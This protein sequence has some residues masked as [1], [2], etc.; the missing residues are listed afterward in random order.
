MCPY[1]NYLAP[2]YL[3]SLQDGFKRPFSELLLNTTHRLLNEN[4]HIDKFCDIF[5]SKYSSVVYCR[6]NY[7][8]HRSVLICC[9]GCHYYKH[10]NSLYCMDCCVK[11][12]ITSTLRMITK[13]VRNQKRKRF[14]DKR[15]ILNY[16]P[17][18]PDIIDIIL[19]F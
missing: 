19:T 7:E 5:K 13:T 11:K 6:N 8:F 15:E 1:C 14:V 18:P 12:Y 9:S 17:L 16:T 3:N 2:W 10:T 4:V